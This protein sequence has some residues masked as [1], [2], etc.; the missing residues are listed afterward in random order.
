MGKITYYLRK[1]RKI[2]FLALFLAS[3]NQIFSLLDPQIMRIIIDN[4][5]LKINDLSSEVFIKGIL[6]LLLAFIGVALVSRIAKNI[7]DYYVNVMTQKV[8]T[9]MYSKSVE[10]T[11]SLP[12]SVFEDQRSGEVLERMKKARTDTQAIITS[13]INIVF[14]ALIGFLFVLVYAFIVHWSIA[15]AFIIT[16]PVM[17]TIIYTMSK[18]IKDAQRKIVNESTE[19]SGST[20]ETIR[21]VELVKSLGLQTQEVKR[22]NSTN[23]KILELELKKVKLIRMLSFVQGTIVN[24]VRVLL[25]FLMLYLAFKGHISVGEFLSLYFYSFF[26]FA[27]L[28]EL[29]NVVSQYQEAKASNEKLDE[30]LKI[31][32][33]EKPS[34]PI[35][36]EKLKSIQL[37]DIEFS[38]SSSNQPSVE[39]VNI[40]LKEGDVAAFVGMSG[41][42]KTTL[43]KLIL[44]L[45]KPTK[46]KLLFNG[47]DSKEIDYEEFKKKIGLVSQETQ[48][49]AG[50]IKDNLLFASP[51]A[52]EKECLDA[53]NMASATPIV[54][55]GEKG[56]NTK[57]GEGGIKISGGERQR[58]A[59]ARALLRNPELL[60]FDEATS[61]LDSLTEKEITKT[62]KDISKKRPNMITVLVAH[63][64]STI[65]HSNKIYVMEKG[66][67]TESGEHKELVKNK[68][69]YAALWRQQTSED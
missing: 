20:T 60:I 53:L 13:S 37:K 65:V 4:Y 28:G 32:P 35:K 48:L 41:S 11:F 56:I 18:K 39:K 27:P 55:R 38:Y 63:R 22:L 43:V 36:I 21:N 44:G 61:S 31:K 10:H 67:I 16:L 7:Q 9:E 51:E 24:A 3:V 50:T 23:E 25:L 42:G 54:E 1:H 33:E 62:I 68:G 2:L 59:I 46:G 6:L 40:D 64:L 30:I 58:L 45:Y 5:L 14:L 19:L 49:F 29:G 34:N 17:A 52:S 66:K 26:L 47:K 12:Y 69:L 57:I 8:G 15:I